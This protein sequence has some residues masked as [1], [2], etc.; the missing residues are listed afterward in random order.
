MDNNL[1]YCPFC[2]A[3]LQG[4]LI[5]KELQKHYGSS[6]HF[7]R[8]IGISSMERDRVIK[9]ECPDCQQQWDRE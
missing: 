6:T 3:N 9:W 5:P 1:E 7:S 2:K 8:K 4:E